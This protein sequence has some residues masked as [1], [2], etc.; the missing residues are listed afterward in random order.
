MKHHVS[1]STSPELDSDV[2]METPYGVRG[3][4]LSNHGHHSSEVESK[5]RIP[6][7]RN[8]SKPT[9]F[10]LGV[11]ATIILVAIWPSADR[12]T[13]RVQFKR[14]PIVTYQPIA[15]QA[16]PTGL[17]HSI[18]VA[19]P[20]YHGNGTSTVC[21]CSATNEAARTGVCAPVCVFYFFFPQWHATEANT[22]V[23][24]RYGHQDWML[25]RRLLKGSPEIANIDPSDIGH[26][27]W[28]QQP[29]ELGYYNLLNYATRA[30]QS[31]LLIRHLG[32]GFIYHIY[33][34]ED[35]PLFAEFF[36]LLL[37]D[38]QPSVPF[39]FDLPIEGWRHSGAVGMNEDSSQDGVNWDWKLSD[40]DRNAERRM[41]WNWV[42][43]FF[44]DPRYV[45]VQGKPI[46]TFYG[47]PA[48]PYFISA[49][50]GFAREG[51]AENGFDDLFIVNTLN[52]HGPDT[53]N[54][55]TTQ[56]T[57]TCESERQIDEE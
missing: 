43:P 39:F 53:T 21:D 48:D 6:P 29:G 33:F 10:L 34:W 27:E 30:R 41:F 16:T 38:G 36:R 46:L 37:S 54:R 8:Y 51:A 49:L 15:R 12:G 28:I 50:R 19:G 3:R 2:E 57:E 55:Q 23:H 26:P 4:L 5:S 44:K 52:Q 32:G 47:W 18:G 31:E 9:M 24:N 25:L 11:I 45:R 13:K 17:S 14:P 42:V 7:C 1:P 22:R 35:E 20:T 56:R 40:E